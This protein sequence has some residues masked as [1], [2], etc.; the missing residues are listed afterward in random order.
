MSIP[1]GSKKH[2]GIDREMPDSEPHLADQSDEA[3]LPE[4]TGM[5]NDERINLDDA[6][7]DDNE[8]PVSRTL[9]EAAENS[10][11]EEIRDTQELEGEEQESEDRTGNLGPLYKET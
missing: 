4:I 5:Q 3:Y 9:V 10:G 6:L 1:S 2:S 7:D 8:N 11:T